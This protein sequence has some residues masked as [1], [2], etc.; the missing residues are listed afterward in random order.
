[1]G[2]QGLMLLSFAICLGVSNVSG[3]NALPAKIESEIV[4]Y[5]LKKD[6]LGIVVLDEHGQQMYGLNTNKDM[7]P[8]SLTKILTAAGAASAFTPGHRFVTQLM[9]E[10]QV[11]SGVLKGNLYLKGGGDPAFVSEKMWYLVN[12]FTRSGIRE[13]TGQLIIDDSLFDTERFDSG[14]DPARVDRAYD[15]P[16]GA[17]SFNWNSVNVFV[18]P[19][20]KVGQGAQVFADPVS[21]YIKLINKVKTVASGSTE[22]LLNRIDGRDGDTLEVSGKIAVGQNEVVKYV[23]ISKPDLFAGYHLS[24]FLSQRGITHKGGITVGRTPASSRVLAKVEGDPLYEILADMQKFSNN[25]VAEMLTKQLA[26]KAGV[27]PAT[28]SAGISALKS[29]LAKLGLP[30]SAYEF[31]SP[32]GLSQKNKI[33][34]KDLANLM[35]TIKHKMSLYPEM[36]AALPI[37]GVDGTLKSRMKGSLA[38]YNVRG[39]TGLLSGVTGLAGY[40]ENQTGA[41]YV[42]VFMYNGGTSYQTVWQFFDTLAARLVE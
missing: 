13:I 3:A 37:A 10:A 4:K 17:A 31:S 29:E 14:R 36:A 30:E 19:G 24:E 35:S 9:S 21:R 32:S 25:F 16:I 11:E 23:S 42:Y 1:M 15:A 7:I 34:A 39:K 22:I 2:K 6:D 40:A 38:Q 5:K 33:K 8:A 27:Q 20:A 28:M 26:V 41:T 18:R 12:E